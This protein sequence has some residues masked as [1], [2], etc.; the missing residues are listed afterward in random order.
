MTR[1]QLNTDLLININVAMSIN[2]MLLLTTAKVS[3]AD[4]K[5][6]EAALQESMDSNNRLS[7]KS[8]LLDKQES[9]NG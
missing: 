4:K 6:I 9:S 3:M 7:D 5:G 8:R 1:E 2:N